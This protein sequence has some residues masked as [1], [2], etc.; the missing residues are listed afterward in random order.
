MHRVSRG[1]AFSLVALTAFG[2]CKRKPPAQAPA[3]VEATPVSTAP[4]PAPAE[5]CD[6][7]C[8]AREAEARNAEARRA[9]IEAAR[10]ALTA[11]I[12]FD[13][14]RSD[15]TDESR[16]KLDAK[17]PV[18][19]QNANVRIRIAGH[20]DSRGSDEYNLALGQRRAAAAKR[21]LTDRGID[22]GRI[23]IVSFGEERGTCAE[24]S[25]SCWS[26]NRRDEFEIT[27]GEITAVQTSSR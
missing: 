9:A 6:A 11:T 2:A 27:G 1:F 20:T 22:G 13:Y 24:E 15:I 19:T 8:R 4:A 5:T 12:Y 7:A 10:V 25:E 26:R 14:D 18:L 23:E 3:P 21:Y 16:A 17:V